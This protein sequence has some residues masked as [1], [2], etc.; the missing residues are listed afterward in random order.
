MVSGVMDFECFFIA[1][2]LTFDGPQRVLHV[3]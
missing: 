1:R 3:F 2:R